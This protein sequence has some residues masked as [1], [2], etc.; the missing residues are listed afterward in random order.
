MILDGAGAAYS[1]AVAGN[2]MSNGTYGAI[3]GSAGTVDLGGGTLGSLG[4]NT[5]RSNTFNMLN[6]SS[7]HVFA[8]YNWWGVTPPVASSI[9][10]DVDYSAWLDSDP[11][12]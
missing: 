10:G 4:H 12:P 8:K 5:F 9:I 6:S 1:V 2:V 11:N 7:G 3:I